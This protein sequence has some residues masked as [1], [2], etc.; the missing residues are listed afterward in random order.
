M[1]L[2]N[3]RTFVETCAGLALARQ[4][5]TAAV[6]DMHFPAVPRE[7]VA[8]ATYPFRNFMDRP[9]QTGIKLTEFA[10]MVADK[11]AIHNI[12]P[13]NSHFPSTE[14]AYL[15]ELRHAVERAHSHIVNI[16]T[17]VGAS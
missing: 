2:I 12:E 10:T 4:G 7:R 14:P 11:F 8:V 13:L 6:P 17:S 3:R 15:D 1:P 9:G 16:P 5:R